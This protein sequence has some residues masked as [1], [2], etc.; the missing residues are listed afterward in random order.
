MLKLLATDDVLLTPAKIFDLAIQP[1]MDIGSWLA[2]Q[3]LNGIV[4][5][6]NKVPVFR[7][8]ALW[9]QPTDFF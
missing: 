5:T 8:A 2:C 3:A 9:I 6:I 4:I 7:Y 1:C